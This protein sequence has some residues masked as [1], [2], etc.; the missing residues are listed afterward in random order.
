MSLPALVLLLVVLAT[1]AARRA[2]GGPL[3]ARLRVLLPAWRF[4]DAIEPTPQLC[5]RVGASRDALGP[6][7]DAVPAVRRGLLLSARSNLA[8]A[9]HGLVERLVSA[10]QDERALAV[11]LAQLTA[12]ARE[13]AQR[14]LGG[15]G[16]FQ[17]CVRDH[18]GAR[19]E[20]A[21]SEVLTL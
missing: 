12:L 10:E 17:W 21:R 5:V 16:V 4:F 14:E 6:W 8:L 7:L 2:I 20:R 1:L 19:L 13:R 3:L 11:T 9:M 15:P 18:D